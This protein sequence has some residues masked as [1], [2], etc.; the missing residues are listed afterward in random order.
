MKTLLTKFKV[1]STTNFGNNNLEANLSAVI[2]GSDENKSFSLYTP[3][4][5][6][7]LHITNPAAIDF[8]EP[9]AEYYVEFRKAE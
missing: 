8:F 2:S 6:V 4:G 3:T 7:K 5:T 1:G 9:G